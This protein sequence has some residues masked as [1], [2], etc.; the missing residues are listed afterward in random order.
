MREHA[1]PDD[2]I[3]AAEAIPDLGL[4]AVRRLR[5]ALDGW[6]R[7]QVLAARSRGWHWSEIARVLGRSRQAVQQ[8]YG[9]ADRG[10][11]SSSRA[12][13]E[14]GLTAWE[15]QRARER[16][17]VQ[18]FERRIGGDAFVEALEE[19]DRLEDLGVVGNGGR[20]RPR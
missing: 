3:L 12:A 17:M 4:P 15:A 2:A 1:R 14:P 19:I 13:D 10:A 9:I 16:V 6:E 7:G 5:G 20:S 11:P 8:R 18:Y